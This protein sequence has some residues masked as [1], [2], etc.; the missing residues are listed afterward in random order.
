[1]DFRDANYFLR[2]ENWEEHILGAIGEYKKLFGNAIPNQRQQSLTG[3]MHR[4]FDCIDQL[5]AASSKL[6]G[7]PQPSK[8]QS[9]FAIPMK[10]LLQLHPEA[11][12]SSRETLLGRPE[13]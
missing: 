8:I 2:V 12:A 3:V 1:M 5:C 11:W 4:M 7:W 6:V 10:A 13:A 9:S